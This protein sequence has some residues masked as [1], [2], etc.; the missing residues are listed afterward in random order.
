MQ[1]YYIYFIY[2]NY[3]LKYLFLTGALKDLSKASR[4]KAI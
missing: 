4:D 1:N 3:L 2:A